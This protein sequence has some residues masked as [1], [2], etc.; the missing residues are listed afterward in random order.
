V[1]TALQDAASV[2]GLLVTTEAMV[3]EHPKK[4]SPMPMPPGGVKPRPSFFS[5]YFPAKIVLVGCGSDRLLRR[6]CRP[7]T[8]AARSCP[9]GVPSSPLQHRLLTNRNH[10]LDLAKGLPRLADELPDQASL[11]DHRPRVEAHLG[12]VGVSDWRA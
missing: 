5:E 10:S 9:D 3:A 12:R 1:R 6:R 4:D 2:A 11:G 7:A 8:A